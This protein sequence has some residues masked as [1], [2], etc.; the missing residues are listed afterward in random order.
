MVQLGRKQ[1]YRIQGGE[2]MKLKVGT[3]ATVK[4]DDEEYQF[5]LVHTGGN[6]KE[7]LS[8]KAP[9]ARLLGRIAIGE[10]VKWLVEVPDGETMRVELVKMENS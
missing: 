5:L 4:L 10:A 6:G 2:R 3:T 7:R 1:E 9:L 8:L